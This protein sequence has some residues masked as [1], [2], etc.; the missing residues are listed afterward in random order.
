MIKILV[1]GHIPKWWGGKQV[2]GLSN[3]MFLLARNISNN[4]RFSV[5]FCSTDFGIRFDNKNSMVIKNASY[6]TLFFSVFNPY[7]FLPSLTELLKIYDRKFGQKFIVVLAKR[8]LFQRELMHGNFDIVH[9][10]GI[11]SYYLLDLAKE[12][13]V[14]L[15]LHHC[16]ANDI[17][18]KQRSFYE[19][20]ERSLCSD[21]RISEIVFITNQVSEEF[22]RKY[23]IEPSANVILQGFDPMEPRSIIE[24][25]KE[26]DIVLT[27][28]GSISERKGQYRVLQAIKR[29]GLPI[30][31]NCIGGCS[32]E[33]LLQK[34]KSF[35]RLNNLK[36]TYKG[37]LDTH[38]IINEFCSSNFV[39]L[40]SQKEGFAMPLLES[41]SLGI[42]VITTFDAPLVQE[43]ILNNKNA[44]LIEDSSVKSIIEGLQEIKSFHFSKDEIITNVKKYSWSSS[45]DS[46]MKLMLNMHSEESEV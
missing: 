20:I 32:D 13:K 16:L 42:P 26:D 41:L 12:H 27:T 43:G 3:S 14:I 30:T 31:Y 29:S 35:S 46:Y 36:F 44:I 17:S 4:S 8:M 9:L 39:I 2:S 1:F 15:T 18:V 45:A 25:N 34:M 33:D 37:V 23:Q 7:I 6:W 19:L 11:F 40:A 24:I 10:H 5:V 38:D 21:R 22:K 28:V